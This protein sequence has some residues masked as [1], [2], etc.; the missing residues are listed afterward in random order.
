MTGEIG[1]QIVNIAGGRIEYRSVDALDAENPVLVFLHEG[2][3]CTALWRDFPDQLCAATRCAGLIYSRFGYGKSDPCVLPRPLDYMEREAADLLPQVLAY[4]GISN[5][6]LV[7]HSDG[8]SIALIYAGLKGQISPRSLVVMAPHVFC[9]DISIRGIETAKQA[10]EQGN[11]KSKLE[12][13][14]GNNTE[15]AF[16]GWNDAWLSPLFRKWTIESFL[17]EIAVPILAIQGLDDAY[18]TLAQIDA[19]ER[20]VAG[21]FQKQLLESCGH[22]PWLEKRADVLKRA[23]EFIKGS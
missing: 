23:S 14:H 7:S 5:F 13:F 2:L 15:C 12:K 17:P 20:S 3:G 8:A 1:L 11:L 21:S 18:G 19:I 16:R 6:I 9:E 4:F 22:N 10:F